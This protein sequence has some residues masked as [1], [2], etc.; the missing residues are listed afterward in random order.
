MRAK[1]SGSCFLSQSSLGAVK[2]AKAMLPVVV[3]ENGGTDDVVPFVEDD[4]PV[5][6]S[7][8]GDALDGRLVLPF[9][10]RFEPAKGGVVPVPGVLFAPAG[11][12]IGDGISLRV[13]R[14][15]FAVCGDEQHLEP[16]R[17]EINTNVY[18]HRNL[19]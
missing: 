3:P 11:L 10:Q 8:E 15:D 19:R 5:H 6:L 2:P 9:E 17:A 14:K 4:E 12:R 1:F 13:F 18:V 7:A 16:A